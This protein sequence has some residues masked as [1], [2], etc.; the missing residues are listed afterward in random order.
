MY[1][2]HI[3][4]CVERKKWI[5]FWWPADS[6][7][8]AS[9]LSIHYLSQIIFFK[10]QMFYFLG[11]NG[12]LLWSCGS[13]V[14]CCR[15]RSTCSSSPGEGGHV[16]YVLLE[17]IAINLTIEPPSGRPTNWNNC[18]KEVL[19][20]LWKSR[21]H[22]RL[23]NLGIQQRGWESPGNLTLRV[24]GFRLQNC[25]RTGET[26]ALQGHKQKPCV[27]QDPGEMSSDPARDWVRFACECFGVSSSGVS[28]QWSSW[29]QE[30]WQQQSWEMQWVD[31][32]PAGG[33]HHW[34]CQRAYRPNI[35]TVDAR[36]VLPQTK[37][38]GGSRA[39]SINRKLD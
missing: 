24:S 3:L 6:L 29:G 13:A 7:H 19:T 35:D 15:D 34:P 10:H 11:F 22:N 31:I 20:L 18:I 27:H 36:I 37:A 23:L 21:H 32:S 28:W 26:E 9:L 8:N 25:H 1:I 39:P 2:S 33:G 16:P 5:I 17:D 30:C 14:A 4:S 12:G 38:K